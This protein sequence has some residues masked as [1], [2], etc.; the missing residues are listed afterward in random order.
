MAAHLDA[1]HAKAGLRAVERD[2]FHEPRQ[3]LSTAFLVWYGFSH[4][5]YPIGFSSTETGHPTRRYR[6]KLSCLV[7]DRGL[8]VRRQ[9]SRA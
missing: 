1:Q 5:A 8:R 9:A 3:R 7:I 4:G 6:G 2:A